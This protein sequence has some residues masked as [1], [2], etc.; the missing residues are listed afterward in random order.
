MKRLL[1]LTL[2]YTLVLA[3][4]SAAQQ[5]DLVISNGRVLD[6]ERLLWTGATETAGNNP[7]GKNPEIRRRRTDAG[8]CVNDR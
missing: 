8:V 4:P 6:P 7:T 1:A 2:G 5:L 3:G